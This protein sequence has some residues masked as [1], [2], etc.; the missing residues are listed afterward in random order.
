[1]HQLALEVDPLAPKLMTVA[2][3]RYTQ[4]LYGL[5]CLTQIVRTQAHFGRHVQKKHGI[6]HFKQWRD[7]W[8]CMWVNNQFAR[9]YYWRKLFLD[10]DRQGWL[11]RFEHREVNTLLDHFNRQLPIHLVAHKQQFNAHCLANNLPTPH[12]LMA[13]T[14]G[15]ATLTEPP[16]DPASDVVIKP[17]QDYGSVGVEILCYDRFSQRY[18]IGGKMLHWSDLL[19]EIATTKAIQTDYIMQRRLRNSTAGAIFGQDDV[20]NVRIVTGRAVNGAPELIASVMR[21]PSTYT[22]FGHDRNVI[23]STIDVTTGLMDRGVFRDIKMPEFTHH[24][25]TGHKMK[26]RAVP[27]WSEMVSLVKQAHRTYPWMPFIGWDVVDSE[28]GLVLLEANAYWGADSI[29]LPG[30]PGL[31][32]TRFCEIYLEWFDHFRVAGAPFETGN[33]NRAPADFAHF[34]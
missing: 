8:H 14:R 31:G 10:S 24:P 29:Q 16:Q 15:G 9:H 12:L 18:Q 13:W 7:L 26:G 21:V 5:V 11:N 3:R 4:V 20:C 32:N 34:V 6:S 33:E 22:T 28:Q 30:A 2:Q 25:D 17:A 27:R 23:F 19:K 1:M